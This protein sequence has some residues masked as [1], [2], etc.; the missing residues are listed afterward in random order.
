M[1]DMF[2]DFSRSTYTSLFEWGFSIMLA[3]KDS[4]ACR[5]T[6]YIA[7]PACYFVPE[8]AWKR[9]F[10]NVDPGVWNNLFCETLISNIHVIISIVFSYRSMKQFVL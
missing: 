1:Y 2:H 5:S 8:D 7:K 6:P 9:F 3:L 4:M 10:D